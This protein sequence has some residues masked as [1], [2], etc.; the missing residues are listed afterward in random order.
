M[1]TTDSVWYTSAGL[2]ISPYDEEPTQEYIKVHFG[3]LEGTFRSLE[4]KN[5]K[6]TF[7]ISDIELALNYIENPPNEACIV[8]SQ[9][10]YKIEWKHHNYSLEKAGQYKLLV[11]VEESNES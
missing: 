7:E 3:E 8:Y 2:D 10:L 6:L 11:T 5:K 4:S 9:F 1:S